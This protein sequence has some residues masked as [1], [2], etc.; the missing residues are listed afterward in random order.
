MIWKVDGKTV[1]I[2]DWHSALEMASRLDR[3]EP[4]E[5]RSLINGRIAL[6]IV[7]EYG[8]L[9]YQSAHPGEETG[10]NLAIVIDET[11]V[12]IIPSEHGKDGVFV[13]EYCASKYGDWAHKLTKESLWD[14][15]NIN[16]M[17]DG[18]SFFADMITQS[19]GREI[20]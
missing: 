3:L 2:D 19:Q 4:G 6:R 14:F 8:L 1:T 20:A 15:T 13:G 12:Y 5:D 9:F 7:A 16:A 18:F 11:T 17:L 10:V